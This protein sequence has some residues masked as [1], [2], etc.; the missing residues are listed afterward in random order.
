MG[1]RVDGPGGQFSGVVQK[2]IE[3]ERVPIKALETRRDREQKKADLFGQ[4]KTKVQGLQKSVDDMQTVR[5]LKEFKATLG[6]GEKLVEVTLDKE[7]IEHPGNYMIEVQDV[8]SAHAVISAGQASASDEV[9]GAGYVVGHGPNGTY[10]IQVEQGSLNGIAAAINRDPQAPIQAEVI[11]DAYDASAPYKLI[12]K[13]KKD[14]INDG[15]Y[16]DFYFVGGSQDLW[17]DDAI[18]AQNGTLLVDGFEIETNGNEVPDF[19]KGVNLRLKKAAPGEA[20]LLKIE[21]DYKKIGAKMNELVDGVNGVLDFI[22]AQ[23]KVDEKS[24]TTTTFAGDTSL[25]SIEYRVRNLVHEG[26]FGG[27]D[28]NGEP[29]VVHLGQLG[30]EFDRQGHVRLNQEKFE[31]AVTER[32]D[33]VAEALSGEKGFVRQIGEVVRGYNRPGDGTIAIRER[34]LRDRIRKIDVDI[35]NKERLTERKVQAVQSQFARMEAAMANLQR[36]QA[37]VGA[38]LGVV[39]GGVN[40]LLGG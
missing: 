2:M 12:V 18:E 29:R 10:D 36:Q 25:Q 3:A 19:L 23:N 7:K 21:P 28:E 15:V 31:A 5:R 37:Y 30:I 33:D 32:F 14:G 22:N 40:Q 13:S 27:W 17:A 39:G 11:H 34:A 26:F 8:A 1:F 9:F 38:T 6:D 20:F 24:D 16:P 4:F 35:A